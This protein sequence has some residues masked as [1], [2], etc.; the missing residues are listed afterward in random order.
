MNLTPGDELGG[1]PISALEH[2][3]YCPR[4]AALIHVERYFESNLDTVRGDLAHTAVN[5]P[6]GG[7]DR[8]RRRVWR[9]LPVWSDELGLHGICDVVQF[10]PGG[11]TPVEHKS[12]RYLPGG[13]ADLQVGAQAVCLREMFDAP[14]PVGVLFSGRDRQRH[15]VAIDATLV[16]RVVAATAAVRS[17]HTQPGLPSAVNDTRCTRCSLRPGCLPEA[18]T[19]A[20][21]LYSPRAAGDWRD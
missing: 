14:V 7:A 9:S 15:E 11:P 19:C 3:E 6:G 16:G 13:P 2:Y 8:S 10:D 18:L 17:L 21:D 5:L 20:D 4:Q 1:V 12:G